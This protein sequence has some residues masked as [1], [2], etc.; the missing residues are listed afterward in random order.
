MKPST[1]LAPCSLHKQHRQLG[2]APLSHPQLLKSPV[3]RHH[4]RQHLVFQKGPSHVL[5]ASETVESSMGRKVFV[6]R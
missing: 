3:G 5:L 4:A 1:L 6:N 2:A